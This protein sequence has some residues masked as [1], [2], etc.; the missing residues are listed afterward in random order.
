MLYLPRR[1]G[2]RRD[3][4][5]V[6]RRGDKNC[7]LGG[8]SRMKE[9]TK[10]RAAAKICTLES[11]LHWD[12]KSR[13]EEDVRV[14]D[15]TTLRHGTW[16][17]RE[18]TC[19]SRRWHNQSPSRGEVELARGTGRK[20]WFWALLREGEGGPK[21]VDMATTRRPVLPSVPPTPALPWRC[22]FPPTSR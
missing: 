2:E 18:M 9:G 8:G 13:T 7:L 14:N 16:D 21:A 15:K 6:G 20:K 19:L 5:K 4:G 10:E 3:R 17:Y 22:T 12:N 1:G 11:S